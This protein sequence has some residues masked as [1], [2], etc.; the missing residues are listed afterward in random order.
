[1]LVALFTVPTRPVSVWL[2]A[3]ERRAELDLLRLWVRLAALPVPLDRAEPFAE[4]AALLRLRAEA[5]CGRWEPPP[6]D[7]DAPLG[8]AF[9]PDPLD[10]PL[11]LCPDREADLLLAIP[12]PFLRDPALP[13]LGV[14]PAQTTNQGCTD[15]HE[16]AHESSSSG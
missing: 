13:A 12:H 9:E 15:L 4:R 7:L 1:L 11:L 10:E 2:V 6:P 16:T 3:G 5:D 14:P 8:F